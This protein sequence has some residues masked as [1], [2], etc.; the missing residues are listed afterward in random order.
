MSVS[1]LLVH[2]GPEALTKS[3]LDTLLASSTIQD[4]VVVL[5]DCYSL[6]RNPR[7]QWIES[8]NRGY[9]AGLNLGVHHLIANRSTENILALNPDVRLDESQIRNLILAHQQNANTCTYPMLNDN[10]H[11][12]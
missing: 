11:L 7:A 9:A 8:E 2:Y 6:E 12:Q 10:G 3:A 5:H 1:A 4:I